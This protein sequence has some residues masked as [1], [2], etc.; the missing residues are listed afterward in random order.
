MNNNINAA[1]QKKQKPKTDKATAVFYSFGEVG[2]QLSWYMINSYLMIYYTDIVG[3]TAGAISLIMLVVRIATAVSSPIWGVIQDRTHSKWGKFRPYVMFLPIFLAIFNVLTFT[4]FPVK[5]VAKVVTC[6]ILYLFT[7]LLYSGITNAY[8]ALVNVIARD[9][10]VRMNYSAAR[11]IGSSIIQ[12]ILSAGAMPLILFFSNSQKATATGYFWTTVICSVAMI[13]FFFFCALRCKEV[14]HVDRARADN[15][16][17][18]EKVSVWKSL[19][20][21]LKNDMLDIVI[22]S[23]LLGAMGAMLRMSMLT[24]YIIYVVGSFNLISPIM[25][26]FTVMSLVGATLLPWGTKTFGKKKWL[27][28]LTLL[29]ALALAASFIYPSN[30]IIYVVILNGIIGFTSSS[31][32]ISFGFVSDCIEYGDW[33]YGI[34]DEGLAVSTLG[35]GVAISTALSGSL[36]VLLLK[37]TGYVAN[38]VQTASTKVGLNA[39][40]NLLPAF[41]ALAS[42]ALIFF[43]KLDEKTMDMIAQDLDKR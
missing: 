34:R 22:V 21:T 24:Y 32:N 36:G 1:E 13:P 11:T 17:P 9:S 35:I 26:T 28:Y 5:G 38:Q 37:S 2:S 3:L 29:Q 4:V 8:S 40:V 23:T 31:G 33:K 18:K 41:L 20:T 39:L 19:I 25:T 27:I 16:K 15:G 43:Y 6:L 42:A 7:G 10:Q 12:M 30:N 14:V